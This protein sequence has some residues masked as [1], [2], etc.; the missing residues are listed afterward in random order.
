MRIMNTKEG[1]RRRSLLSFLILIFLIN[2]SPAADNALPPSLQVYTPRERLTYKVKYG[3]LRV[4][5]LRLENLGLEEFAGEQLYHL[6]IFVDSNPKVP[7]VNIHDVY[8]SYTT[9][10]SVPYYF[11]AREKEGD[12]ILKTEY[13]FDYSRNS[14]RVKV[15]KVFKD[16]VQIIQQDTIGTNQIYRDVLTLLFY[17]RQLSPSPLKDYKIPTFVLTGRDS[18]YFW[19][20][21]HIRQIELKNEKIP[22]YYM[23][24]KVKFI[25]IAGIKDKFE[26]WFSIDV[27]HV[28]LKAKMKAF[29]GSIK[30]ELEKYENWPGHPIFY[31]DL[32]KK[33]N[34]TKK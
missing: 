18:C 10:K 15:S 24:G 28:P 9:N 34:H 6:R 21:G 31:P 30:L 3:F 27:A 12:H 20:S 17:A 14:I 26:G 19:E 25:G 4:G 1:R 32:M 29:F 2:F 13:T 11:V 22:A 8:E 16:S 7:F 33:F 5:T 23:S